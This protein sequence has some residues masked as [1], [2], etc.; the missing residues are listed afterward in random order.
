MLDVS[1][2]FNGCSELNVEPSYSISIALV[3]WKSCIVGIKLQAMLEYFL[4]LV[5]HQ[6]LYQNATVI[7]EPL[8]AYVQLFSSIQKYVSNL[9]MP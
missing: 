5:S 7:F 8:A 9:C 3:A 4:V 2:F 6:V 1:H